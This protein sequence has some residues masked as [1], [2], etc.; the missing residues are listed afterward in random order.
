MAIDSSPALGTT[1]AITL[2]IEPA[3][4]DLIAA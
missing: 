3:A 1:V 4:A 2:P